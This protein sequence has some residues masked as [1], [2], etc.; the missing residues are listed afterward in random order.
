MKL[1]IWYS[2]EGELFDFIKNSYQT[3]YMY[4][5]YIERE[6]QIYNMQ[7]WSDMVLYR[8]ALGSCQHNSL[9]YIYMYKY[10]SLSIYY[11]YI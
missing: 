11:V 2:L 5:L 7:I 1:V 10:I 3:I 8:F 9:P 6:H 4:I